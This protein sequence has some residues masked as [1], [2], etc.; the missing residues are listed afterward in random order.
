MKI[1]RGWKL[2]EIKTLKNKKFLWTALVLAIILT[3]GTGF[4]L[5]KQGEDKNSQ[6]QF[7]EVNVK[8]DDI[9]VGLDSDGTLDFSKVNLRFGVKG[10]IAE[11]L[12]AEGDEVKKGDVIARLDNRDYQDQYQL[13]LARLQESR[14]QKVTSLL[15]DELK[16][17]TT[18]AELEK[19]R[20]EYR[21]MEA[22]PDAYSASE[23]KMKKMEL[24]NKEKEY[25]NLQNKY[26]LQKAQ[27]LNQDELEVKMAKENLEDT[28]LYA[29]V[30]GCVLDLANKVGE[31]VTDEQD[32]AT[33]HENNA[34]NAVT[35][36]IEYDIGQIKVGQKVYV[37]VEAIPDKKFT[38]EVSKINALP[39][40]DSSGLVNY[41]VEISIKD[42]GPELRDGM[43]CA[44]A[45]VIKEV[46]DCLIVPYNAVR[47]VNGKQVV[48]VVDEKGQRV[49]REIKTGFTDGT[50][51]EVL[52]G[53]RVNE[54]VVYQKG[55]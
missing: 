13:A 6:V 17:K 54:K 23:L 24:A 21:E 27:G 1:I 32:F 45:F 31:S 9:V 14:E 20:D 10:K 55:R 43:T 2:K 34:I 47:I 12:V 36:V 30:S 28:V 7:Q 51:V 16:L 42:P 46:K 4:W 44:V 3:G 39:A 52:E 19:L 29:P 26:E 18:E 15:D 35:K 11:I 53:L 8:R 33:I 50:S 38:G 48:T 22:I 25:E 49:E 40:E 5:H 37:T 41:S